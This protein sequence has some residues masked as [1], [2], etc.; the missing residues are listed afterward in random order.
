MNIEAIRRNALATIEQQEA[1]AKSGREFSVATIMNSERM[2]EVVDK[3]VPTITDEDWTR[4]ESKESDIS[5]FKDIKEKY[6]L[7]W[8]E[9]K[10]IRYGRKG[11]LN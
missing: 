3:I 9:L 10:A 2:L 4:L 5:N 7:S 6:K 8:N 1:L 11:K